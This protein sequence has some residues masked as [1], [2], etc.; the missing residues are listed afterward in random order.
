LTDC[1]CNDTSFSINDIDL[2]FTRS[3]IASTAIYVWLNAEAITILTRINKLTDS[4]SHIC[5]DRTGTTWCG[6]RFPVIWD[7]YNKIEYDMT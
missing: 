5:G 2:Y 1:N 6:K 3:L 7:V 4:Y